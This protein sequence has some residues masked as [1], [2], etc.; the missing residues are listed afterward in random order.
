M[1]KLWRDRSCLS[2]WRKAPCSA[3]GITG[4]EDLWREFEGGSWGG[5]MGVEESCQLLRRNKETGR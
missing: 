5:R 3:R 4:L 1:T 2:R